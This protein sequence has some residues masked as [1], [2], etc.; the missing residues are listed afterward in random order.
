MG[1]LGGW[2]ICFGIL[3]GLYLLIR[4]MQSSKTRSRRT[5]RAG[6]SRETFFSSFASQQIDR[7]VIAALWDYFPGLVGIDFPIL[8]EDS[9]KGIYGVGEWGSVPLGDVVDELSWEIVGKRV[10][11]GMIDRCAVTYGQITTVSDLVMFLEL[12]R[13]NQIA[14][15]PSATTKRTST[16]D[17]EGEIGGSS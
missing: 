5:D 15:R 11:Q 6:M 8:P 4:L 9:L 2:L 13:Q 16:Q 3:V 12:L 7:R 17:G 10:P 14:L 1:D